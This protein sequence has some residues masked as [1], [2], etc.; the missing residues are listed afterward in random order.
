MNQR[1]FSLQWMKAKYV[2]LQICTNIASK[3]GSK[4]T[5]CYRD[6]M[7]QSRF[8]RCIGNYDS[9]YDSYG[10]G[11]DENDDANEDDDGNLG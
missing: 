7:T 10:D 1:N 6:E 5:C 4:N 8:W 2:V 9:N 3:A 11:D